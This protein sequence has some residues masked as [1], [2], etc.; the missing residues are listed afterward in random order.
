MSHP[1]AS[2]PHAKV[3]IHLAVTI[4]TG[5]FTAIGAAADVIVF[6]SIEGTTVYVFSASALGHFDILTVL[7]ATSSGTFP[8][9]SY[10]PHLFSARAFYFV[11][12]KAAS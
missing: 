5:S 9:P 6:L 8:S 1:G 7:L 11:R 2:S 10:T 4:Q 3:L 12:N